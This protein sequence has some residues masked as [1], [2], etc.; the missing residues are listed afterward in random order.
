MKT[1]PTLINDGPALIQSG[2][3]HKVYQPD[4]SG[5]H[6][7]AVLLHGYWG[8][9]DVMWIF[10]RTLPPDWLIIAPRGIA[11]EGDGRYSWQ[12]RAPRE[13]PSLEKFET[14]AAALSHFIQALPLLYQADSRQIHFMGFSQGAAAAL[15]T[16]V[17]HPG[18][19]QAIASLV[20]FMPQPAAGQ[21][22][23][24][25][26]QDLP[27]FMAAGTQDERVPLATARASAQTLRAAGA[28][29]IYREY[30]VGHKLNAQGMRDLRDWWAEVNGRTGGG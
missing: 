8:N 30:D 14:A 23:L 1:V 18:S 22:S 9:E 10:G 2:L 12:P 29:L 13:W 21:H 19:I 24:A 15:A 26:L 16:A 25:G 6:P 27:V 28:A 11:Q 4:T 5:P 20:G 3:V 17:L 7:T